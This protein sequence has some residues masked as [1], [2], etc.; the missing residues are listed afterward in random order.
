MIQ[1]NEIIT[2]MLFC[3]VL[4]FYVINRKK[5]QVF[6]GKKYFVSSMIF[7]LLSGIFTI[8]EG[9]FLENMFNL[10][11]HAAKLA[12]SV[13]ILLWIISLRTTEGSPE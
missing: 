11:E 8:A 1:E 6:P 2:F 12:S 3:L 10:A 4:V 5:L 9:F 13:L 7:L